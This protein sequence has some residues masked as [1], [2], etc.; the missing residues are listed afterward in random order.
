M[1]G[2]RFEIVDDDEFRNALKVIYDMGEQTLDR[3]SC[4]YEDWPEAYDALRRIQPYVYPDADK[5]GFIWDN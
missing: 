3:G 5:D 2:E 1:E 4:C